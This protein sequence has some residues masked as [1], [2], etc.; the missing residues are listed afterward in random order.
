MFPPSSLLLATLCPLAQG[1]VAS[2]TTCHA[3]PQAAWTAPS[4]PVYL[5]LT[6][7]D[8][9]E[10]RLHQRL[11][12]V[13]TPTSPEY[14]A[15]LAA[16]E[17]DALVRPSAAHQERV[18]QWLRTSLPASTSIAAHGDAIHF[19]A[20]PAQ[21]TTLFQ[22]RSWLECQQYRNHSHA[23][24]T[25]WCPRGYVLPPTVRDVVAFVEMCHVPPAHAIKRQRAGTAAVDDRYFGREAMLQ[26][27]NMSNRTGAAAGASAGAIEYQSNAGFANADLAML[28]GLNQQRPR[29][30]SD[31]HVVGPNMGLDDESELDVQMLAQTADG[32]DVWFWDVPLWLYAFAVQFQASSTVPDV[33]SMSWGW[34]EDSQCDIIDCAASNLTSAAY[35][36][37]VNFEYLK[38][39]L[40][41]IT[42]VVSSGDAGAPGRTSEGCDPTRAINPVFPGSS[43]YVVSVGATFVPRDGTTRAYAT[44]L[45]Q[46]DG[47]ITS[48]NE[49]SVR[50]DRVGWTAGGGFD[51]YH[52][53]TPAWQRAAVEQ[54]LSSGVTLP[55]SSHFH[56]TGRAYPDIS[57][58]GHSCPTSIAGQLEGVDGTSCS[59]PVVAGVLT[60]LNAAQ[61]ARSRS[62]VGF[63]N[64]L[65]YDMYARCPTCFRDVTDGYNW[66]TEGVCCANATD[67]GFR[68]ITGWDPVTGVGTPNVG[69]MDAFLAAL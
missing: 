29:N 48:T 61:R 58:I 5:A 47:C 25:W 37:R 1:N 18:V 53:A 16:E 60:V 19:M 30:V 43:P 17:V 32:A 35:V 44:P 4:F 56:A 52:N 40:R 31:A 33:I 51:L 55:P 7:P 54:Y 50:F 68:A 27:Y 22:P 28:Q 65:L 9:A 15:W 62:R 14:G 11:M 24:S 46:Q 2:T 42:I 38:M 57:A 39:A 69:E 34:A 21:A 41:G 3:V 49:S 6:V 64:P 66:C 20:T 12:E 13:S 67:F 23:R 63:V 36:A 59:A 45:C 10:Q 8:G 26:L